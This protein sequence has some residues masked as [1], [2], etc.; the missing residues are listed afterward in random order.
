MFSGYGNRFNFSDFAARLERR[1]HLLFGMRMFLFVFLSRTE[2]PPKL[3][4]EAEG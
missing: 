1:D 2:A 3:M 4:G